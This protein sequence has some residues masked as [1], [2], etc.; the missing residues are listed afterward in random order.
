MKG[1]EK[2]TPKERVLTAINHKEPDKIPKT[3]DFSPE[4]AYKLRRYLNLKNIPFKGVDIELAIELGN[5]ML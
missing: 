2:M 5:D 4:F 1:L 3:A